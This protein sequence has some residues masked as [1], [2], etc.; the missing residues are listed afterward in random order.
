MQD[1]LNPSLAS[2]LE[3]K[4]VNV[5]NMRSQQITVGKIQ[6]PS[7][8]CSNKKCGIIFC[9]PRKQKLGCSENIPTDR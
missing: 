8:G 3:K 2:P 6:I 1:N 7:Y 9:L 5:G 4:G